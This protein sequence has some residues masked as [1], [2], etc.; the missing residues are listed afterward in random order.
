HGDRRGLL[1]SDSVS[2][3]YERLH[4]ALY[5]RLPKNLKREYHEALASNSKK[6]VTPFDIHQT[7][8]HILDLNKIKGHSETKFPETPDARSSLLGQVSRVELQ[9][10]D[11][12]VVEDD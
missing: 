10:G 11:D 4:P 2:S 8:L 5:I 6:F 12:K 3:Y 9:P 7:L 1:N